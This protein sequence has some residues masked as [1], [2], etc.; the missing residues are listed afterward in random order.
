[1]PR[2]TAAL[3]IA[4]A[5]VALAGCSASPVLGAASSSTTSAPSSSTSTSTPSATTPSSAQPAAA[6][7]PGARVRSA[8][9][10]LVKQVG[11]RAGIGT[12]DSDARAW[13]TLDA[14]EV[15]PACAGTT[16]PEN[17]HLIALSFTV[18]TTALLDRSQ[19]WFIRAQHF[20]VVGPDG[21]TDAHLE[22]S[23]ANGCL[24]DREEL[25]GSPYA[26]SSNYVG[27][28]VLDSRHAAGMITYRPP[29][30]LAGAGWEWAIPAV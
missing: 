28:V 9:G 13:F 3:A 17:G 5:L 10:L 7:S 29:V 26:A 23:A 11:E 14:I 2:T 25:P 27:K 18:N 30:E 24:P 8:R 1:M 19:F 21:I 22:T 15:D 16:P 20:E 6:P 4:A 12:T